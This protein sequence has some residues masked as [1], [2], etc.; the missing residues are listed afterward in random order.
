MELFQQVYLNEY[1]HHY[2]ARLPQNVAE[3]LK[4]SVFQ[5]LLSQVNFKFLLKE[6]AA[7]T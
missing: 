7:K 1:P 3:R 2:R 6:R 4:L 5:K